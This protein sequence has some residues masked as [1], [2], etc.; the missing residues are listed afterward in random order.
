GPAV[1]TTRHL[2]DSDRHDM[3]IAWDVEVPLSDGGSLRANVYRPRIAQRVPAIVTMGPYSKDLPMSVT[4]PEAWTRLV[5][6]HPD[7]LGGS[8]GRYVVWEVP[9]PERWT[10]HGY[11]VVHI[12][13][14][15]TGRSP[16]VWA[17]FSPRE[18]LDFAEAVEWLAAQEW[19]TG[20]VG[21][22]GV[23]YH[24]MAA[25]R[26]AERQPPHLAAVIPWFGS[27]DFYRE[28]LRHGGVLSNTFIDA[29]W[30]RWVENQHGAMTGRR[31]PFTGDSST[32]PEQLDR[33]E[34]ERLREDLPSEARS[35]PLLDDWGADRAVD[36]SRVTVPFLSVGNWGTVGLH[37]RGNVEAF[38]RAAS[39]EKWLLLLD[40]HGPGIDRFLGDDGLT[41]QL[42]FFDHY[43]KDVANDWTSQPRVSVEVPGDGSTTTPR[44]ATRW[45]LDDTRWTRLH[46]DASDQTMA[47][48]PS[49]RSA[50]TMYWPSSGGVTF[51]CD[52]F[53][54]RTEIVG[55]LALHLQVS[56]EADDLDVFAS[57]RSI[58]R[59]GRPAGASALGWLRL[60]HRELDEPA[61]TEW[62]PVHDHRHTCEVGRGERYAIDV[63][64]WPAALVIPPGGRLL[65]TVGGGDTF[66]TGEWRHN[67]SADRPNATFAGWAT[68]FSGP[69][70]PSWLLVPVS[71]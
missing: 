22:L 34:L 67:D 66:A 35:H 15:G 37:L 58:D 47:E 23:S 27:G 49:G 36:W 20:K 48:D 9:D 5:H 13:A 26:V 2:S 21:V 64:L 68:I 4:Y 18:S 41:M 44:T 29:W 17:P 39:K 33:A 11:A 59:D 28:A 54:G 19:C 10:P 25:W 45:P 1:T 71:S 14:R 6:D 55:P 24:A 61:S 60:S 16:G 31:S 70:A 3:D 50:Q 38:R 43:L 30:Y 63:E 65:L 8:S 53:A 51:R 52:P 56:T 46:L 69:E 32:G 7:V 42:R 40:A 12:D 57:V 62:S